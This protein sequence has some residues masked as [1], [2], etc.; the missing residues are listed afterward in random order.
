MRRVLLILLAVS[1]AFTAGCTTRSNEAALPVVPVD[2]VPVVE[3]L[4]PADEP[5]EAGPNAVPEPPAQT[6]VIEIGEPVSLIESLPYFSATIFYPVTGVSAAVDETIAKW[7]SDVMQE[8]TEE[9][10]ALYAQDASLE[11][12]LSFNFS[13]YKIDDTY[14]SVEENGMF[15]HSAM[16]HPV[17]I[18]KTFNINLQTG[19]IIPV[20]A[21]VPEQGHARIF[22]LLKQQLLAKYPELEGA[23]DDMDTSW[24]AQP[25]LQPE[26]II[27]C[28]ERG[29][30][31]TVLGTQRIF[32][33][34]E[35][36]GDAV[37]L[38][39]T[40]LA[41]SAQD[42]PEPTD[43]PE[44][45]YTSG[46]VLQDGPMVALTFDDGPSGTTE[47][48][49]ALLRQYNARATFCLVGNRINNRKDTVLQIYAQGSEVSNHTWEHAKLTNLSHDEIRKQI[50]STSD[51]V[52]A[53]TGQPTTFLRPPYGSVN[54][55]VKSVAKELG[56]AIVTWSI[57]TEDWKTRNSDKTYQRIMDQVK[58]GS[59]ILCHDL[60]SETG[61]AMERVIPALIEQ[62]YQL[63]TVTE[64]LTYGGNTVQAGAVYKRGQK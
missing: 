13:T 11:G 55:T 18:I 53:I 26:G 45:I 38:A 40:P 17:D 3:I 23:L 54:D 37:A 42:T 62:G 27:F 30:L 56:M 28:L 57:D 10:E 32:L 31:P 7:A 43:T 59:I 19:A 46:Q 6:S 44:T 36:L 5:A 48:I 22:G 25:L 39:Q 33:S 35:E 63:V 64:L 16:A 20:D 58:D 41:Q 24:L 29:Q 34:Y 14:A 1:L 15:S 9:I 21:L 60:F 61:D 47:R 12:E 52:K 2:P 49:L 51:A 4:D 8:K 50:K